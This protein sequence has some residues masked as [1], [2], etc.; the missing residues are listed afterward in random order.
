MHHLCTSVEETFCFR[1]CP[2]KDRCLNS[3]T[4][5]CF[6]D[7]N[8]R[9]TVS[10]TI[11][12]DLNRVESNLESDNKASLFSALV[13]PAVCAAHGV[14]W[15]LNMNK[16]LIDMFCVCICTAAG[17]TS[18]S[19]KILTLLSDHK[20]P[21]KAVIFITFILFFLGMQWISLGMQ[22]IFYTLLKNS[23]FMSASVQEWT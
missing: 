9:S 23:W 2:Y 12:T 3:C 4:D 19:S 20:L 13:F 22:A 14:C 7:E 18:H 5:G 16:M 15:Y 21:A 17:C 11:L 6:Q 1:S 10:S 8:L